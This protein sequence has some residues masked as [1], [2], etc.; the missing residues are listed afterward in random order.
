MKRKKT[1]LKLDRDGKLAVPEASVEA[2]AEQ[3]LTAHGW[4]YVPTKAENLKRSGAPAHKR[5]TLDGLAF[6]PLGAGWVGYSRT[7]VFE[8]K[9]RRAKTEK[10]HLAEQIA[11]AEDLERRG[12]V[13]YR[14]PEDHPDPIDHFTHWIKARGL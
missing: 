9:R 2:H 1:T 12:V 6:K 7:I 14:S 4:I 10:T 13:V 5:A 11:T 8:W 3:M